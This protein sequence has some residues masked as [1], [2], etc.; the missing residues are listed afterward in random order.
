MNFG[1][2]GSLEE[3]WEMFEVECTYVQMSSSVPVLVQFFST[4]PDQTKI[5]LAKHKLY[6]FQHFGHSF[7]VPHGFKKTKKHIL[8][9]GNF[10]NVDMGLRN[11]T[12]RNYLKISR[13]PAIMDTLTVFTLQTKQTETTLKYQKY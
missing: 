6:S 1:R 4:I 9:Y 11:Q 10:F 13:V 7:S 5:L 8:K 3:V 12:N 2:P